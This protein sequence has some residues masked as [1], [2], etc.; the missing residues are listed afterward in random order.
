MKQPETAT[1]RRD[2]TFFTMI[3]MLCTFVSRILGFVRTAVITAIFGAGGKA[4]VINATFAVPNNLR[5]L[6]AEGALSSAFIPVLSETIVNEDA[7]RSRSSLL[8]RTLITFQLLIL[9]PFTILAIIFAEPLV[10]HVVTQ[11]KDPA[12]IAL[13]IDLFRY[14]IVYLLLIS[15]SSVLMGLLN[16]HDRFFIPA[17]TPIFFSISVISSI[18]IFHRSLGVFSMAVGVLAG[19]VGQILFQIPQA[20]RLGYRFSPSF[21]FRSDD[22]VKILHRWLPVLATSSIFTINQQI[23]YIFASGLTTGSVSAL[24]YAM[25]FWQLPFGIFSA[26]VTTVLFPK[27]SRQA[28]NND[29]SGLR[30]TLQYGIRFLFVL[31]IPSALFLSFFGK[32]TISMALQRGK[33][34]A[35]DTFLTASVLTGYCWGLFSVGAFN[36]LQRFFYSIRNYRL[37]FIVACVVATVDIILSLILKETVLGVT[38]LAVANSISFTVGFLI[39]IFFAAKKLRGFDSKM[40]FSTIKK[41]FLSMIPFLLFAYAANTYLGGWWATGSNIKGVVCLGV[42][43]CISSILILMMYKLMQVEMVDRIFALLRIRK[44]R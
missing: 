31:L 32:E 6:L 28:G 20:M 33:F 25:V 11:F 34:Y 43:F 19:G 4:D 30:D 12:Q 3:V 1:G 21:H 5:K 24:S 16:S 7:K 37:P 44:K 23:A 18:L 2:S 35:D 15:V 41:V 17:F 36:F 8:V 39:L 42:E 26:S 9:I 10:R 40:V 29:L 13:S 27:M 22:F 38:G 14:F